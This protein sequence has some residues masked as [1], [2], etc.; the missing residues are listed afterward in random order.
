MNKQI[1]LV[2]PYYENHN[3]LKLHLSHWKK[4]SNELKSS[5]KI[6][7][8]DDGSQIKP[9]YDLLK[10]HNS[11]MDIDLYRVKHDIPWNHHGARNL[12]MYYSEGLCLITDM[13]HLLTKENA[14]NILR[15]KWD[16]KLV[17][18]PL[19]KKPDGSD[20]KRHPNTY[21]IDSS[22]YWKIGGYD[23]TFTGYWGTDSTFRNALSKVS[24]IV[25]TDI[26]Y[27]ILYG[28]SEI[29]DASTNPNTY[30]RKGTKFHVSSNPELNKRKK[31]HHSPIKPLNFEWEKLI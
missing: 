31:Q 21:I 15:N 8:V 16:K 19:R 24:K 25:D 10:I 28:R 29:F 18:K 26:F 11:G 3:M 20:Y 6:V 7:I 23:E 9:A 2:M 22:I 30:G 27:M 12:G 4:Y 17:Y 14:N 1:T 5:F 13:D